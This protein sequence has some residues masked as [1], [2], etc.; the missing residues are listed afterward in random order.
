MKWDYSRTSLFS[1]AKVWSGHIHN[2]K[3]FDNPNLVQV[4]SMF[5]FN[6]ADVNT[7][8]HMY[9]I[10]DNGLIEKIEN[11]VSPRFKRF[12]NDEIFTLNETDFENAY[13]QICIFKTNIN[14]LKYI[15]RIKEIKSNY[16]QYNLRIQ[17]ID[18]SLGETLELS[19]F[20]ANIDNY[21][22]DNIP[23]HLTD[24]YEIVKDKI[25]NNKEAE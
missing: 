16:A 8:K 15:E 12:F 21:I 14:Q 3:E 20:N 22:H 23:E 2:A 19:Y 7:T 10:D 17:I 25:Q 4:G 11:T 6:F 5:S 13:V 1:N 9:L 24:K 18:N